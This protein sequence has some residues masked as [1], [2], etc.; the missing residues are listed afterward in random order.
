MS[1]P[2]PVVLL[3]ARAKY[4]HPAFQ[5]ERASEKWVFDAT[6]RLVRV[7]PNALGWEGNPAM[8]NRWGYLSEPEATNLF[9]RSGELTH[10]GWSA[11]GADVDVSSEPL[12]A[13][14]A[15]M[16]KLEET[17]VTDY[18][19]LYQSS[20]SLPDAQYAVCVWH[21]KAAERQHG[22]VRINEA[23]SSANVSYV[24]FDLLT[25]QVVSVVEREGLPIIDAASVHIG[26]GVWRCWIVI[27]NT[28]G[29]DQDVVFGVSTARG[30]G[31]TWYAG[32]PGR[33]IY[34]GWPMASI[35]HFA[36]APTSYIPTVGSTAT[37]PADRLTIPDLTTQP[38]WR[39]EQGTLFATVYMTG[40]SRNGPVFHVPGAVEMRFDGSA[41]NTS[42]QATV[43]GM[44]RLIVWGVGGF[45]LRARQSF[46]VTWAQGGWQVAA[47]GALLFDGDSVP[48]SEGGPLPLHLGHIPEAWSGPLP[49]YFERAVY[50]PQ[51]VS[52]A[53]LQSLTAIQ[54]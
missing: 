11:G 26:G 33:G 51:R 2:N 50:Y 5:M 23:G 13:P 35:G 28:S 14:G 30:D 6:G 10:G 4:V 1:I 39:T 22:S 43:A 17:A 31:P 40:W 9:T 41:P 21:M 32:E 8:G 54:E 15:T 3:D 24:T 42:F 38:W 37:R 18:H 46:A 20:Q 48:A 53:D 47:N 27:R 25:G 12:P 34:V 29:A 7:P 16:Y 19:R 49:A 45:S 52:G 44:T 36:R